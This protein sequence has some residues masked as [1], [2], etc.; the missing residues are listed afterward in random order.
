MKLCK[1]F[2]SIKHH[3]D[4]QTYVD[5][6]HSVVQSELPACPDCAGPSGSFHKDGT[7]ERNLICYEDGR[8]VCHEVTVRCMECSCGRSHALLPSVVVPYSSFS[9]RFIVCLL[10]DRMTKA[11]SSIEKL[12]GH[13]DISISTFYRVKTRFIQDRLMMLGLMESLSEDGVTLLESLRSGA[14][15]RLD[16][17]LLSF[18]KANGYSFLQPLCRI[19]PNT[20]LANPPPSLS[21]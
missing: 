2:Q 18:W 10:Y 13:Y 19:R 1:C 9:L 12:C 4:Y 5:F 17:R 8:P 21:G 15:D 6:C 20:F 11:F 3:D 7:Y 16:D 14:F